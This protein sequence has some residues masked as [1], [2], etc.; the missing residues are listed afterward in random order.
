MHFASS[1]DTLSSALYNVWF[2]RFHF[3]LVER[4]LRTYEF[5]LFNRLAQH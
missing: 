2:T 1:R 3:R 4:Q 5:F